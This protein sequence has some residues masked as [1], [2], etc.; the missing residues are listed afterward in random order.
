M[1]S[2]LNL[3]DFFSQIQE[4]KTLILILPCILLALDNFESVSHIV[5]GYSGRMR[6]I[7]QMAIKGGINK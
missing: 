4:K 5:Y 1:A 7:D 6:Y 3:I 2:A